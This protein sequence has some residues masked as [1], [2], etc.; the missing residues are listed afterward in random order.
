MKARRLTPRMR[1]QTIVDAA[2]YYGINSEERVALLP[3]AMK[4]ATGKYAGESAAVD[5][6]REGGEFRSLVVEDRGP[7]NNAVQFILNNWKRVAPK[8]C[9]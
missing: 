6:I 3:F 1:A 5:A 7:L 2:I 4:I 8:K 9:W